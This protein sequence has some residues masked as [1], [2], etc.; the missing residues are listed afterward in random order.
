MNSKKA[1][2]IVGFTVLA[3]FVIVLVAVFYL[4]GVLTARDRTEYHAVF[5]NVGRLVEGGNVTVAG[6]VV[7]RVTKMELSER[8]ARVEFYV[9]SGLKVTEGTL[10]SINA[11]DVFGSSSVELRLGQGPVLPPG[12]LIAGE[13][14]PGIEDIMRRSAVVIDMTIKLLGRAETLLGRMDTFTLQTGPVTESLENIRTITANAREFSRNLDE[15]DRLLRHTLVSVDS[16]LK[17]VDSL[18][19]AKSD[20]VGRALA[21][22][23]S[24]SA[25]LDSL[26]AR[27]Q[28]GEGTLG[29]LIE[30]ETL[31]SEMREA[32]LEART[33]IAEVR[34]H[35]EKFVR[36]K[37]F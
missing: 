29:R 4:R 15:Y 37:V 22:I 7:G 9:E 23:E 12:S 3:A 17:G 24:S 25:R 10:A 8:K 1:A 13:L 21:S 36:V 2:T 14:G 30:D 6:V 19:A 11:T 26:L 35:P 27:L 16:T 33:L 5:D 34:D 20:E 18:A 28:S 32:L 31:Y